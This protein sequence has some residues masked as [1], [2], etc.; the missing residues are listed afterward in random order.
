[1]GGPLKTQQVPCSP[2]TPVP[3]FD[4]ALSA[5]KFDLFADA[6][7]QHKRDAMGDPL[8]VIARR[9]DFGELARLVP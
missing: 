4:P 3:S 2:R 9:I 8:Q 5:L 7:R 1:M 6:S